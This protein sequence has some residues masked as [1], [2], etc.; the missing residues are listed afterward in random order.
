VHVLLDASGIFC[1]SIYIDRAASELGFYAVFSNFLGIYLL[2]YFPLSLLTFT[3][4]LYVKT[5]E[6]SYEA[7]S[8]LFRSLFS[9]LNK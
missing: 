5:N 1:P 3:V 4:S 6:N 7:F 8:V 2:L 9:L